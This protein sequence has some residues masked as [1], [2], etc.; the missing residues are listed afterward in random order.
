MKSLDKE[1]VLLIAPCFFGYEHEII[2]ELKRRGA[3]VDFLPDR[4]FQSPFMKAITRL[5]RELVI[6]LAERFFWK[7]I[8]KFNRKNYD[9]ILVVLGECVSPIFLS[10]LKVAFPKAT[11]TLY[12][13]DSFKNRKF[14]PKNLP[15]FDK[16]FTFDFDDAKNYG[17]QFRPLFYSCGFR[18]TEERNFKFDIS[19]IGTAHSDR[20]RI[21]SQVAANLPKDA[22]SYLYLFL[23]A[24][25]VFWMHKLGNSAFK[26][27][28]IG[29]FNFLALT[30]AE[31]QKVFS[32]SRIVLDI[33][34]PEQTGLT[35][36]TFETLGAQKK[37]I[38][39]NSNVIKYD[40]FNKNNIWV[41]DR[42][43][44]EPIPNSFFLQPYEPLSDE[45]YE[46]YSIKGWLDDVLGVKA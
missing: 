1:N 7:E 13:W 41:I 15:Y 26:S 2:A 40:F 33:E 29:E 11:F 36:R 10:N 4:P 12:M 18:K 37:M 35:M 45:I 43:E 23:Q 32:D 31:V 19:F 46:K 39:T 14:L 8:Q 6:N 20:Y 42:D 44:I 27:A 17:M 30:K 25:W 16:C 5:R 38:T 34:H 22:K 28:T 21:V 3:D 24:P 9:L